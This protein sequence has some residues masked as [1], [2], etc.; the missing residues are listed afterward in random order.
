M[1]VY[2]DLEF[3]AQS[4]F[5]ASQTG[6]VAD[7]KYRLYEYNSSVPSIHQALTNTGISELGTGA[8]GVKVTFTTAGKYSVYWEITDTPYKANEEIN[9]QTNIYD[10]FDG[11]TTYDGFFS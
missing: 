2:K 1:N 10:Y 8:Y 3:I 11:S 4:N 6:K 7:V 9:V 5:P